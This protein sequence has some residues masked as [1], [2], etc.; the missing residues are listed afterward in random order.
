MNKPPFFKSGKVLTRLLSCNQES[1]IVRVVRRVANQAILAIENVN[2]DMHTNGETWLL[3]RIAQA[4]PTC[5]FDV[6]ANEGNWAA[7]ALRL[8]PGAEVHCF[9]IVPE[10]ANKIPTTLG[11]LAAR[12]H[13]NAIGLHSD[14]G[15]VGLT[16]YS[17]QTTRTNLVGY[18]IPNETATSSEAAVT[19]GDA[20]CLSAG[21]DRINFLKI[22]VE[23]TEFEVLRGFQR[24][25]RERRVDI[26]QFEYGRATIL[27]RRFLA[28]YYQLLEDYGFQI[29]KLF[30]DRIAFRPYDLMNEDFLGPNYV[31]IHRE[32]LE[33]ISIVTNRG[34]KSA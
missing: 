14:S 21:I 30:P 11:P 32:N 13:I 2:Y 34:S 24:M 15:R 7:A 4:N 31:A 17:R 3:H 12:G 1:L 29:G 23:G 28:D 5:V 33:T 19:T 6:G 22:D 16:K 26:V 10:V 18:S 27:A 25:L 9:E 20:Y 8:L